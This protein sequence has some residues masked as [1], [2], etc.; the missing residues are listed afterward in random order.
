MSRNMIQHELIDRNFLIIA[1]GSSQAGILE[2]P[3][4]QWRLVGR[5]FMVHGFGYR[6]STLLSLTIIFNLSQNLQHFADVLIGAE[7]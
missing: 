1:Y 4:R 5:R 2:M 7:L 6:T 3:G